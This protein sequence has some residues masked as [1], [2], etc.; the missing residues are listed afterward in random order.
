MEIQQYQLD[1]II[2]ALKDLKE[3][4]LGD[5]PISILQDKLETLEAQIYTPQM[6]EWLENNPYWVYA[7]SSESIPDK[8]LQLLLDGDFAKFQGFQMEIESS[9][10]MDDFCP[11]HIDEFAKAFNFEDASNMPEWAHNIYSENLVYSFD[12]YWTTLLKNSRHTYVC[13]TILN[14]NGDNVIIPS[15][16]NNS[17]ERSRLWKNLSVY[18][19]DLKRVEYCYPDCAKLTVMGKINWYDLYVSGKKPEFVTLEKG[20]ELV[21]HDSYN[22]AGDGSFMYKGA[23]KKVKAE[24]TVDSQFTYGVQ[25]IFMFSDYVWDNVLKIA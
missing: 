23:N 15:P 18:L 20:L 8:E 11:M 6:T 3:D 17:K 13:A 25:S 2:T 16:D 22:G 1:N 21:G 19:P 24:F 12:D 5:E 7:D 14:K 10:Y 4:I 9:F